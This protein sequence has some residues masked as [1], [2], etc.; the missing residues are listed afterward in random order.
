MDSNWVQYTG[1]G[2]QPTS[3]RLNY[4]NYYCCHPSGSIW[5]GPA[6][7]HRIMSAA[8]LESRRKIV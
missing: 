1:D 7:T 6:L 4:R 8:L 3:A 2:A 5:G